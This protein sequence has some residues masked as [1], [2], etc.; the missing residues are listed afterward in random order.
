MRNVE[1]TV[2]KDKMMHIIIITVRLC[3]VYV[4]FVQTVINIELSKNKL[5]LF[6]QITFF[7]K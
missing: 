6:D 2:H 3:L 5:T 1:T 4:L 7:E